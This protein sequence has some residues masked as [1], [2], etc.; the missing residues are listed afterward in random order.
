[1]A[2]FGPQAEA[3]LR[4]AVGNL[5]RTDKTCGVNDAGAGK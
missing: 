1:M 3:V 5:S 4:E 2:A